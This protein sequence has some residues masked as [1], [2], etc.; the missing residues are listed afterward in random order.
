MPKKLVLCIALLNDVNIKFNNK[1]L[2]KSDKN[3]VKKYPVLKKSNQFKAS[4]NIIYN[5]KKSTKFC[6]SHKNRCV[7]VLFGKGKIGLDIEELK[8]RNFGAVTQ[9]CF[10]KNELE[11]YKK[12]NDIKTFYQIYT[13]KEAI[14]KAENLGFSELNLIDS[15]NYKNYQCKSFIIDDQFMISVV[16][17][18]KK[19]II[20]RIV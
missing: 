13:T 15:L 3:R 2:A 8:D 18:G 10:T 12:F 11:V 20:L 14:V 4:R 1:I 17:K 7:G 19:D 16:F 5:F 9:F 6:I